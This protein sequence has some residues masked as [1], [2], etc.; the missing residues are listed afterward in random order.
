MDTFLPP[1]EKPKGLIKRLAYSFSRKQF[2]K[3]PTPVKVHS[4]RLPAA[5]GLFYAKIGR[6]DQK[7]EL[8]QEMQFLIREQVARINVCEFCMDIGRSLVVKCSMDEAKFDALG[9]YGSSGLFSEKERAALDYVTELT[10]DKNVSPATF[11]K[12]S[13]FYSEREICEIVWLVATEH[14]Y[15]MTNIGLNTHS[16][17]LCDISRKKKKG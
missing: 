9:D 1:I 6:L 16:D 5:F 8:P 4:A 11:A 17:M 10:K 13:Q 15:N 7:L 3:V 12:M 14:V 2:G